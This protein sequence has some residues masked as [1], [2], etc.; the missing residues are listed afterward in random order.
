[1]W[2]GTFS[3]LNRY[4]GQKTTIFR[5]RRG[6]SDS[7]SGSVIFSML[8]DSAGRLW[9]GTDG[10]GLNLFNRK[11]LSF[12]HFRNNPDEPL[13]LSSNQVFALEEDREGKLWIGTA[14]GGLCLYRGDGQFFNLNA[15]NSYLIHNRIRTL[16]CDRTGI[17]W[18]GTEK[19]LSLYDTASGL[20]L[21]EPDNPVIS[22]L[23]DAF[24][25]QIIPDREGR[26][27]IGTDRGLFLYDPE[28]GDIELFP[29]PEDASVRSVALD[30]NR[31]WIGTERS[32][33]FIFD[34]E[35]RAWSV[36]KADGAPG[37]LSYGKIRSI[38]RD[39]QGLIWVGTRGG[40]VNQY[41]P[42]RSLIGTYSQITDIRQ[43]IERRDGSIWIAS[44]GGGIRIFNRETGQFTHVDVDQLDPGADD[45]QVYALMEDHQGNLWIG[46]DGSGLYFLPAGED[47]DKIR[48]V[49]LQKFLSS[50]PFRGTVWAIMEDYRHTVW[51]GT[52]GAGLF[53]LY[54]SSFSQFTH[55]PTDP[56]SLNGNA[57]RCIFEDSR[58]QLWV[59]TW[60]GGLNRFQHETGT[61]QSF[62]RSAHSVGS[63]SDNSVNVIFEDSYRRLWVGTA[64]GGIN[65]FQLEDRRFRNISSRDGL[66]GD[67]I[68][69][70]L[71]DQDRN[72]WVSSDKGLSMITPFVED[73]LNFSKADGLIG[74]EF[75]Q[76][77]FLKTREGS[78]VFGGPDGISSFSPERLLEKTRE[79]G[80]QSNV[81][82][83]GLSI[84]NL[85]VG[86]G[87]SVDGRIILDR[88]ISLKEEIVL[89][90]TANNL[91]I[92]FAILSF[93]D[94]S[95]HHYTVKLEGLDNQPRFLGNHNEVSYASLPP[96][97]YILKI[98]GS[99]HNGLHS[100]LERSLKIR[101]LTPFW[102]N[103][104]FYLSVLVLFLFLTGWGIRFRIRILE[105]NNEQLRNFTMHMEKA[106]EEE[107]KAAARDYHDELGQ[108]LT[109]MKFD[110][111]W[112]NSHPDAVD[113]VRKDKIS[114]LL[115]LVN[116]SIDSVRS[117]STH[118]RPKAL[119]NLSLQEA[120]EWQSRRFSKRTGIPIDL[121]IQ[122]DSFRLHDPEGEIKTAVF[123]MYQEILTNII[124]HSRADRVSVL[125]NQDKE[126]FRL[127]VRDN[128]Q[129]ID[130]PTIKKKNSFGLIGMRERC[131]HLDGKFFIDNH[132]EGG[133]VVRIILPLKETGDA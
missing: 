72:L 94:P 54:G 25:R 63:L 58:H 114:S 120:L 85:P 53:A 84:H 62:V 18:V 112:L 12:T 48:R 49:S 45:D 36:L 33:L 7:I 86:I 44:D 75:S 13:S 29:L 101:I 91:T 121:Q 133:T 69:G 47:L 119:D 111:F 60:D 109:A 56:S 6:D 34:Y 130:I 125:I 3:G 90:H 39:H 37:S 65:I 57:V 20:F 124:R 55:N 107:R 131:R 96:G 8:E 71:E 22:G 73:I 105:R 74:N 76:N 35:S 82:I 26:L 127:V 52:E 93:I 61:F 59:G 32:G 81:V 78:L 24:I 100:S 104:W 5:P 99:D 40:G 123:R 92:Q 117:L 87:E 103:L 98:F 4:D 110:L 10:G 132:P 42:A 116:D 11:T 17:L 19:G 28:K 97:E 27:W 15:E 122:L 1:M 128:G 95:K 38:Y 115:E 108:Q 41:N 70:I 50:P 43:M 118:L 67:N 66:S 80:S 9:I 79:G 51:I 126:D 23:E 30:G 129:G 68:Y 21:K 106:R 113:T 102:M 31:L 2:F 83:T 88:D 46:T 64:G 89:P 77:A 16:Y 14:G